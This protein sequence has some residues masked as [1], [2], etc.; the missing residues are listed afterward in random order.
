M[1]LLH[2][3][4]VKENLAVSCLLRKE[5][6][7]VRFKWKLSVSVNYSLTGNLS[8]WKNGSGQELL[9]SVIDAYNYDESNEKC[10]WSCLL[11]IESGSLSFPWETGRLWAARASE[12]SAI[13]LAL[14]IYISA[15][16]LWNLSPA[17]LKS[18]RGR[19]D[20]R[21]VPTVLMILETIWGEMIF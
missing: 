20:A 2:M 13:G 15:K 5:R 1:W 10:S 18:S 4:K 12:R 19:R 17:C 16:S 14:I 9:F 6:G 8:F 11:A 21:L 7:S 3:M